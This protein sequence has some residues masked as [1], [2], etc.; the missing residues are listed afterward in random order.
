MDSSKN[1]RRQEI[2]KTE[3]K[4]A[5]RTVLFVENSPGGG[6]DKALREVTA[7]LLNTTKMNI[8]VVEKTGKH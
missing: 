8:K 4:G 7:R 3:T 1:T 5:G 6:L 2:K